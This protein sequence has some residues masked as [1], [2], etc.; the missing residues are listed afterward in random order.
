LCFG[1]YSLEQTLR[2]IAELEFSK[3]DL[4]ITTQGPHLRPEEIVAD[5][6]AAAHRLRLGPGLA[7]VA[8]SLDLD[9]SSPERFEQQF[10]A[11]CRLARLT[12]VPLLTVR[13]APAGTP[14][15]SEARRLAPWLNV[16]EREGLLFCVETAMGTL[17]E[18]P[19][20]TVMLC[21][22]VPGLGVTLDPSH[23]LA[24]P[25]QGENYDQV[26]PYVR[27]LHLRDTGRGANQFQVRVGQGD[28]GFG[29]LLSQLERFHYDRALTVDMRDIPEAAFAMEPEVRKLKFLL[30]S[31]V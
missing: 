11:I 2:V 5:V 20:A 18:D 6:A 27:H 12:S 29:R 24:G 25:H 9:P 7:P 4:A 23:Y 30:E 28:I 19:D 21:Q 22:R 17:T 14:L 16:A 15:D 3:F 31:L 26:L 13:A 10:K 1:R 8:F